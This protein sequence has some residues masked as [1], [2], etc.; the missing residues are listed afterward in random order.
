MNKPSNTPGNFNISEQ[1]QDLNLYLDGE[2]PFERQ[3]GLFSF[4]SRDDS[5]RSLMDSVL[6]F[7]RMSRQEFISLPPA[8]D[9]RFFARLARMKEGSSRFDRSQDRKPLWDT[10]KSISIRTFLAAVAAVFVIGLMLPTSSTGPTA[11]LSQEEEQVFFN[12]PTIRVLQSY[13]Y[14]FEPGL[15]IEAEKS[16]NGLAGMN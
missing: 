13:I 11:F 6:L 9:D 7:R 12:A 16:K 10:R 8:A 15:M 3:A 2:L 4:L 14:V 5:A 1:E